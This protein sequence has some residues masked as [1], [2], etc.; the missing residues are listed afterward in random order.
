MF[1][2]FLSQNTN[3]AIA[4][5]IITNIGLF[6]ALILT[7][8][9]VLKNL[10]MIYKR[11]KSIV[12]DVV[13][14]VLAK[15]KAST[16]FVISTI[17]SMNLLVIPGNIQKYANLLIILILTFEASKMLNHILRKFI[18]SKF[19]NNKSAKTLYIAFEKVVEVIVYAIGLILILDNFGVNVSTLIAGLGI[20]GV[21]AALAVQNIL[22]DIFASVAIYLDKPFNI[23]DFIHINGNYGTVSKIGL[24]TTV[25]KTILGSEIL[26]SNK[27]IANLPIENLGR[28]KE[29]KIITTV[30]VS[31]DTPT[32]KL[33]KIPELITGLSKISDKI[34]IL[35]CSLDK[36]NDFSL[37]YSIFVKYKTP[38]I[39][40]FNQLK[41][42]LNIAILELFEKEKIEI[43]FP[44]QIRINKK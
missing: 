31:Y 15:L 19:E 20:S 30:G 5:F 2:E 12:D 42:D 8:T 6:L 29:R 36:L 17:I 39:K 32:K 33:K 9:F 44:T 26:I 10:K 35:N 27:D 22:A 25:I 16:I 14:D 41:N 37:D 7:K 28:I 23:G 4:Y 18:A 21:A 40:E 38:D 3:Q 13:F 34:E 11:T 43:P 1:T 24:K